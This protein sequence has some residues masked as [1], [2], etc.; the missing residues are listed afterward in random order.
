MLTVTVCEYACRKAAHTHTT[1][2]D[3]RRDLD[4]LTPYCLKVIA[5]DIDMVFFLT[6]DGRQ[7]HASAPC[8]YDVAFEGDSTAFIQLIT[9]QEDTDALFFQRRLMIEGDTELALGIKNLIYNIEQEQL[10]KWL[11][12]LLKT[13]I[14]LQQNTRIL[15]HILP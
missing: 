6:F 14:T 13:H 10:P 11:Q 3:C 7:L 15:R 12:Q 4:F 2:M 1:A 9:Q 8:P 5:R